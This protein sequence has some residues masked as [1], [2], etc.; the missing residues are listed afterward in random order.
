MVFTHTMQLQICE[1]NME[2]GPHG[3]GDKRKIDGNT[4]GKAINTIQQIIQERA[5]FKQ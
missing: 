1:S 3:L 4:D 5:Q 2:R